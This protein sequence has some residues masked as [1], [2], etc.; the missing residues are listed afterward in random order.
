M[1][2]ISVLHSVTCNLM[3][4]VQFPDFLP[5]YEIRMAHLPRINMECSLNLILVEYGHK[6][7]VMN[8]SVII[9]EGQSL[10]LSLGIIEIYCHNN[11][12]MPLRIR[13]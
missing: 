7:P 4:L 2:R 12:S 1:R 13:T 10:G 8:L 5:G 9:A 6:S 3:P 11:V